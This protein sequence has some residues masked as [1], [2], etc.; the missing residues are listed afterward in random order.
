MCKVPNCAARRGEELGLPEVIDIPADQRQDPAFINTKGERIGR[1]G[2]RVPIPWTKTGTNF[3]YGD[4]KPAHLPQ[5]SWMGE[6][7]VETEDGDPE[8]T[9]D[10]YRKALNLRRKLQTKED[11]DWVGD[12]KDVLHF[13]RDGGWD[14]LIN[15][16]EAHVSVPSGEVLVASGNLSGGQVPPHTTVWVKSA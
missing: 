7:S 1:D 4:G 15:M 13:K 3:G 5:P 12:E 6:Y 8:S 16:S 9:L 2:C 14:V 10:M 11:L